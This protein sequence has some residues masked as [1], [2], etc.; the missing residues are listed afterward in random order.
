[1]RD[2]LHSAEHA[3]SDMTAITED[4]LDL[5]DEGV[6]FALATLLAN[7]ITVAKVS[8][9]PDIAERARIDLKL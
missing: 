4:E 1:M 3:M 6:A 2:N 5:E 7:D 8:A 9:M